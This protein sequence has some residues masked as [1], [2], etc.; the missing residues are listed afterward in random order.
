MRMK[1]AGTI[2]DAMFATQRLVNLSLANNA[3][4]GSL[5]GAAWANATVVGLRNLDLSSNNLTGKLP[6][7]WSA[8]WLVS[9]NLSRNVL[10]G[11]WGALSCTTLW[12]K[13]GRVGCQEPVRHRGHGNCNG[14]HSTVVFCH[15]DNPD[16]SY[17]RPPAG[18]LPSEWSAMP[19]GN[20]TELQLLNNNL[21]GPIPEAWS[22]RSASWANISVAGNPA[23]CGALPTWYT[24]RFPASGPMVAGACAQAGAAGVGES[25][26][27]QPSTARACR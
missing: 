17:D 25:N 14:L 13:G 11:G 2:P 15:H 3:L 19:A 22:V 26:A 9:L 1:L 7:A 20:G 12:Q 24:A 23:M 16:S 8:L 4:S 5:G 6:P 10:S 21:T 18:F 27:N